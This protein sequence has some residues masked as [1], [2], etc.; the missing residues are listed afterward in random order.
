MSRQ[1]SILNVTPSNT[2]AGALQTDFAQTIAAAGTGALITLS[3]YRI[4][5]ISTTVAM[6]VSFG[7]STNIQA[8]SA[9]SYLIPAGA[10]TTFDLGPSC[11]SLQF[12][13]NT[14]GS[15]NAYVKVLSVQ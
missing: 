10:Q 6:N 4:I 14:A 3:K 12:F 1:A 13:N 15:G 2:S 8:P 9:N 5:V 7:L 11:D